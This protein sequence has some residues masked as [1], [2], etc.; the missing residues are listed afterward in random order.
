METNKPSSIVVGGHTRIRPFNTSVGQY[1]SLD[2]A[3]AN[4]TA[5]R[6]SGAWTGSSGG[7]R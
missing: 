2:W 6:A 1:V 3:S 5:C 7:R 4:V